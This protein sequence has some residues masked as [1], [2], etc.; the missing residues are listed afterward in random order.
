M[1][2]VVQPRPSGRGPCDDAAS[3]VPPPPQGGVAL[4][5]AQGRL[6]EVATLG[7]PGTRAR[8]AGAR[9]GARG[10]VGPQPRAG[11][12]LRL[13]RRQHG[14]A[15]AKRMGRSPTGCAP[16]PVCA[17]REASRPRPRRRAP[18]VRSQA[19]PALGGRTSGFRVVEPPPPLEVPI[20][21]PRS[22]DLSV[23]CRGEACLAR[24]GA[25]AKSLEHARP[26]PPARARRAL[27]QRPRAPRRAPWH[28]TEA[29]PVR[30]HADPSL[31]SG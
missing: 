30:N 12:R 9:G 19:G 17:L 25:A 8:A 21:A 28:G 6:S 2:R 7:T 1:K 10:R 23:R 22:G 13:V 11:Q 16:L 20:A 18:R 15:A 4:R 14:V 27:S 24:R 26:E 29:R 5:S 31:R 3:R